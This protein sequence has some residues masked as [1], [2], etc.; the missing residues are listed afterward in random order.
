MLIMMRIKQSVMHYTIMGKKCWKVSLLNSVLCP[1]SRGLSTELWLQQTNSDSRLPKARYDTA[2]YY[3]EENHSEF[4]DVN[5][6]Y[7]EEVF[8]RLRKEGN[9]SWHHT[10]KIFPFSL[11]FAPFLFHYKLIFCEST[12]KIGEISWIYS[13]RGDVHLYKNDSMGEKTVTI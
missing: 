8:N 5:F 2:S 10:L 9:I 4:N 13:S 1:Y 6:P 11:N 7:N 3:L 12:K